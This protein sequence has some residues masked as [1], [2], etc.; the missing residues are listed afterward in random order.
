MPTLE[1]SSSLLARATKIDDLAEITRELG[2]GPSLPLDSRARNALALPTEILSA[3]VARGPG[4]LRALH[5]ELDAPDT[6]TT[7]AAVARS[8][9]RETPQLLWIVLAADGRHVAILCWSASP[10][11]PRIVSLL[12]S[13]DKVFTSDAETVCAL[14]SSLAPSDLL[15]HSRYLDILGRQSITRRFFRSLAIAVG[16][17]AGSLGGAVS[18]TEAGEL[19]LVYL[20][21]LI[22]LSFLQSKGWLDGDFSFLENGYARCMERGGRYQKRVLEPL[23]FGT[24]NTKAGERAARAREFGRIPFLNGGLFARSHLEKRVRDVAFSD[25][26]IGNAFGALLSRYR[27]SGRE[28]STGWSDSSID[29]EILGKA[30]ES[31]MESEHRKGSGAFYTPQELVEHVSEEA[32]ASLAPH[33]G[34]LLIMQEVRVIDPACGSGAFLVYMLERLAELRREMGESGSIADVRRRVLASSIFGVDL[35]PTAVWLCE[36]RLWLSVVVESEELD[37]MNVSPLPNLDR[38]IRI[39]DSL[40]GPGFNGAP[41]VSGARLRTLRDRYVR[42]TGPR[43]LSLARALDR[44]E[45]TA[46]IGSIVRSLARL[47][48]ERREILLQLRARDLF[49]ERS[50]LNGVTRQ[51]LLDLRR[52]IRA[53]MARARLLRSGGALPFSFDA[54]FSDAGAAGGFDVVIGNPPWI[55]LHRIAP[56]SRQT[57]RRTFSVYRDAAWRSGATLAGAG[58]GF[59]AQVDMAA[60]F[61]ERSTQLLRPGG[62][63]ALLLPAK[64]WRSLAGG[65]MRRLLAAQTELLRL[66]DHS[67]ARSDFDAAVYPSLVVS[68]LRS[69]ASDTTA[70]SVAHAQCEV[71][72]RDRIVRWTSQREDLALDDTPGSPWLTIPPDVRR[73]FDRIREAGTPLAKSV[74]GRA[75]LGVKTGCNDAFIVR[76]DS[77]SGELAAIHD[78]ERCAVIEKSLLRPVARGESLL[79]SGLIDRGEHIIWPHDECG[80]PLKVLPPLARKWLSHYRHELSRRTDLHRDREWWS[81]FRVESGRNDKPR[82]IW[83]DIGKRPHAVAVDAGD[84]VVPLNSCYAARCPTLIDARAFETLL[85]SSLAAAWLDVTAEPARGGY[86]RYLGWTMAL[87]PIPSDWAVARDAL[88]RLGG[89][90]APGVSDAARLAAALAAY[91]LAA[92]DAEPLLRWTGRS[93]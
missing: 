82:V 68:R 87:L 56:A 83:N 30:F 60:L 35:N 75:L 26:A 53:D 10:R 21:R 88:A 49:G 2:F 20:S 51:R 23:F 42:A 92:T 44:H 31:L 85:N 67:E 4:A 72:S 25:E 54:Q 16:E 86:H 28:D 9:A 7:V 43:K 58:R 17:M 36:L 76:I 1:R 65:G 40:A 45:R 47:R 66:E 73:A 81:L 91:G 32:L 93:E 39:G 69:A 5:L 79:A 29:P 52:R 15:T 90:S 57:L 80:R 18:P 61:V 74:F 37:P 13:R 14:A 19:A 48:D 63:A 77:V 62:I 38:H 24:L 41:G 89:A 64:L 78:G 46:A 27:F 84:D 33:G 12:A 6:R 8:L 3:A 70:P 22:F 11:H 71:H 55:R 59:A 50:P 34:T